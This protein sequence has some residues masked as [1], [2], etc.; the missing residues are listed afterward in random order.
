MA[1]SEFL[2]RIEALLRVNIPEPSA[3]L[4][5]LRKLALH[6]VITA[7]SYGL[8]TERAIAVFCLHMIRINPEF[9][10]QPVLHALLIEPD[11]S[12]SERME[13]LLTEPAESDWVEAAAM[14]DDEV[15][16]RPFLRPRVVPGYD[17]YL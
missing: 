4:Y 13:R 12:E 1:R 8:V 11:V 7:E 5:D 16:W 9:H 2:A 15:Y 10:R 14:C 3:A 17:D 6:C